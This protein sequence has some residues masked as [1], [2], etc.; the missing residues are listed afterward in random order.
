MTKGAIDKVTV[1][2]ELVVHASCIYDVHTTIPAQ[3]GRKEHLI[4][5]DFYR[6]SLLTWVSHNSITPTE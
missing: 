1:L 6:Y 4:T 2:P 3:N 5:V